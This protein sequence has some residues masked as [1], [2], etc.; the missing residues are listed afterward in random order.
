ME[1]KHSE[2]VFIENQKGYPCLLYDGH[3]YSL[4]NKNISGSSMWRCVNRKECNASVTLSSTKDVIIRKSDHICRSHYDQNVRDLVI[5]NCKKD[6]C[7]NMTPIKNIFEKN[8]TKAVENNPGVMMFSYEEKKNSLY[9]AR[10]KYLQ[11]TNTEFEYLKDVKIPSILAKDFLVMEDGEDERIVVFATLSARRFLSS[12]NKLVYFGDGTF[13]RVPKP[14]F[15]LFT[16]HVDIGTCTKSTNVVPV[17]FVLLPNKTEYTYTRLF[18]FLR[19]QMH[20]QISKYKS[21][22]ETAQI[23]ACKLIY[24]DCDISGCYFHYN[25]AV[26]KK[27]RDQSVNATTEGRKV[28]QMCANLPLLPVTKI[29]EAWQSIKEIA[30]ETNVMTKFIC[31][32]E[33]QWIKMGPSMISTARDR[34]RTTNTVE[35]WHRRL[36]VRMPHKPTLMRFI[37]ILRK[38]AMYQTTRINNSLFSGAPRRRP[39]IFFDHQYSKQLTQLNNGDITPLDFLMK[40]MFIK[41]R[42]S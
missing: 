6:A 9:H 41:K 3:K 42:L 24:P 36:N 13:K 31:Y 12:S 26:W 15:Q 8:V 14:F 21:D 2:L 25:R 27:A 7:K 5:Y 32:M 16:L 40:L 18:T 4:G 20:I 10:H 1:L 17:I 28:V 22:F 38:E 11:Q 34:H 30:P 37:Y 19:D 39:D 23:N 29:D 35:G 33:K